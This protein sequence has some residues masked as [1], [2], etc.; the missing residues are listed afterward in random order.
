MLGFLVRFASLFILALWVGAGAAI[1]FFVAPVVFE[2]AGSRRL[3]GEIMGRVLRRFDAYALI[4]GAVAGAA[5]LVEAA[6][7]VGAART[8]GLKL[9]LIGAMLG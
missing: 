3:A 2:Q 4:A 7:T 6:G 9:A 8:L 5:A 1:T